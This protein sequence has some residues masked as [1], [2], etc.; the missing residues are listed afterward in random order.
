MPVVPDGPTHPYLGA[1]SGCWLLYSALLAR[2]YSSFDAEVHRVSVDVYAVQHPGDPSPQTV[3]SLCVHLVA[4]CLTYE[5][6][7]DSDRIQ[8]VMG[9]MSK[10]RYFEILWLE[11]PTRRYPMT[12]IDLLDAETPDAY[13]EAV[14]RWGR[15]TW[16]LWSAHHPQVRSWARSVI[17][18][19]R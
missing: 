12:V 15:S 3:Q 8:R 14:R 6:G 7:W 1:S 16:G 5:H 2:E 13:R 9:D 4:M 18:T 11:P 10:R 19:A 17:D